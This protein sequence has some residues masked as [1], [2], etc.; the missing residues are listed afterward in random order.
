MIIDVRFLS[1]LLIAL[2]MSQ[3]VSAVSNKCKEVTVSLIDLVAN[4][5]QYLGKKLVIEGEF[6]AFSSL[7]LDYDKAMRSSKDYIG[8]MLSRPD[9]KD[10]PL[11]E[12]KLAA[13][14]KMFKDNTINLEHGNT[15]ILKGKVYAVALGE[16][17][18]DIDSI[19]VE[20]DNG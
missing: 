19:E 7:P 3:P 17:W 6:N 4:P 12:L 13:P 10:I 14:L 8:L 2:M 15:V 18:L 9:Q 1:I 16:P 20:P 5:K 11:V